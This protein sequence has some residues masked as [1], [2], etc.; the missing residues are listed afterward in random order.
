MKDVDHHQTLV[1]YIEHLSHTENQ[2]FS[3]S[4]TQGV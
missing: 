4:Q 1:P 3:V 2:R